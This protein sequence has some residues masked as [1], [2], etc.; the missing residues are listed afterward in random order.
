MFPLGSGYVNPHIF[1]DPDPDL[2]SQNVAYPTDLDSKP[3]H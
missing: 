1:A 3:K 2:G